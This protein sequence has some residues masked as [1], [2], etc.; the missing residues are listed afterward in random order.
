MT[1][2][3]N[4][5]F[6]N[7]EWGFNAGGSFDDQDEP[8]HEY[9]IEIT[10]NSAVM[11]HIQ[12]RNCFLLSIISD[13][14]ATSVQSIISFLWEKK[15]LCCYS[16]STATQGDKLKSRHVVAFTRKHGTMKHHQLHIKETLGLTVTIHK[17]CPSSTT[18]QASADNDESVM[19]ALVGNLDHNKHVLLQHVYSTLVLHPQWF[20]FGDE[21]GMGQTGGVVARMNIEKSNANNDNDDDDDD[22]VVKEAEM[23][24][25]VH[26]DVCKLE[27]LIV[28]GASG[29]ATLIIAVASYNLCPLRPAGIIEGAKATC[30]CS[31]E[32]FCLLNSEIT[33]LPNTGSCSNDSSS[34]SSSNNASGSSSS[35]RKQKIKK[36]G[37]VFTNTS[38]AATQPKNESSTLFPSSCSPFLSCLDEANMLRGFSAYLPTSYTTYVDYYWYNYGFDIT[39]SNR[40]SMMNTTTDDPQVTTT[41]QKHQQ[42]NEVDLFMDVD[43]VADWQQD[44]IT[45]ISDKQ[46]SKR[47]GGRAGDGPDTSSAS[48]AAVRLMST[49]GPRVYPLSLL[50]TRCSMAA[51]IELLHFLISNIRLFVYL[52]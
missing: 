29:V 22:D 9:S 12:N 1:Y 51:F 41:E 32:E 13:Y 17:Y 8:V 47:S 7:D 31:G 15:R 48:V 37:S 49:S 5:G 27:S 33:T 35:K 20:S 40:G 21:E 44:T 52:C 42:D 36:K 30:L 26:L 18:S 14:N 46:Q 2:N 28:D 3:S 10:P 4:W 38:A 23:P 25:A 39:R 34:S 45:S 11:D 6:C 24:L 19:M 50:A 16:F 43:L